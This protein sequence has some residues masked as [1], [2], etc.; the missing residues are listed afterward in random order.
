MGGAV[1]AGEDNE[2][3]VDKLVKAHYIKS[4]SIELFFRMIDRGFYFLP[5]HRSNAYRDQAWRFNSIHIS[6]PCIYSEVLEALQVKPGMSFLNVG[7]GTGYLSTLVGLLLGSQG[8]NHGIELNRDVLK[9]SQNKLY[10]FLKHSPAL[11]LYDFVEPQFILGNA[12]TILSDDPTRHQYDRVYCGAAVPPEL[13]SFMKSL[14][15]IGGILVM[16]ANDQL[17]QVTRISADEFESKSLLSVTFASL[18][19]PT[20]G[21]RC[22]R[23]SRLTRTPSDTIKQSSDDED[24][25]FSLKIP[26]NQ[27]ISLKRICRDAIIRLL[28]KS[29]ESDPTFTN[30]M[31]SHIKLQSN[32]NNSKGKR[33]TKCL[34]H[35]SVRDVESRSRSHASSSSCSSDTSNSDSFTSNLACSS[36]SSSSSATS[37]TSSVSMS[38]S[39]TGSSSTASSSDSN[40]LSTCSSGTNGHSSDEA[41]ASACITID[42]NQMA[43]STKQQPASDANSN[44]LH[45]ASNSGHSMLLTCSSPIESTD[46]DD[47]DNRQMTHEMWRYNCIRKFVAQRIAKDGLTRERKADELAVDLGKNAHTSDPSPANNDQDD[48]TGE[49]SSG[50]SGLSGV[51]GVASIAECSS[52]RSLS[53]TGNHYSFTTRFHSVLSI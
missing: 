47:S 45:K 52:K 20:N 30:K 8:I 28:R 18:V 42:D 50:D 16:P 44:L 22:L 36:A 38:S 48:M 32:Q 26:E 6:A 1:S 14:L 5:S 9:Y 25:L 21:S 15:T 13:E 41:A 12:I 37:D 40:S 35:S 17:T 7:S 33:F 4:P 31:S 23:T 43:S 49:S 34:F 11:Y 39:S 29:V 51:T 10:E 2:E 27:P 53:Q 24:N 19:L 3:L 46:T